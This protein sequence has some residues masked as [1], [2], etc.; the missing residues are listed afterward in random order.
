M[1]SLSLPSD[2]VGQSKPHTR[3]GGIKLRSCMVKS[4][5]T[6]RGVLLGPTVQSTIAPMSSKILGPAPRQER[7]EAI[8]E[9]TPGSCPLPAS[10]KETLRLRVCVGEGNRVVE[11]DWGRG[12][13]L[14]SLHFLFGC[15]CLEEAGRKLGWPRIC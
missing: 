13:K 6:G 10:L 1:G 14:L 4:V 15:D 5:A 12:E 9:R 2:C 8:R 7:S 3:M 11:G